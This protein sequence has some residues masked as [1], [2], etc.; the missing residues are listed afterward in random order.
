MSQKKLIG[1]VE[2]ELSELNF[3]LSDT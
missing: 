1:R 2:N 3:W